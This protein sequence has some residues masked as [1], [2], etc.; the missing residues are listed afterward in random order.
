MGFGDGEIGFEEYFGRDG[1]IERKVGQS[2]GE[3]G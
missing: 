2:V 1:S 3:N